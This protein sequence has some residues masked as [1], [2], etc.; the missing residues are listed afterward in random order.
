ME[1]WRRYLFFFFL[2]ND[3]VIVQLHDFAQISV[4]IFFMQ[5]LKLIQEKN[6]YT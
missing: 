6:V 4:Y 3:I 5:F 1:K 2:S